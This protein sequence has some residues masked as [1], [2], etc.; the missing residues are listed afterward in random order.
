M[1]LADLVT[2][3]DA[4]YRHERAV[5]RWSQNELDPEKQ[6]RFPAMAGTR[7]APTA[8]MIRAMKHAREASESN[9]AQNYTT[10][11][12]QLTEALDEAEAHTKSQQFNPDGQHNV[13]GSHGR[14]KR[15]G[16][17]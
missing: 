12:S 3:N 11:V 15:R 4:S 16:R 8:A 13:E 14:T 5:K 2:W 17:G 1:P 7:E 9:N 10:A 6:I